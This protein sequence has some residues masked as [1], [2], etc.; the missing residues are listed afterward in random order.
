MYA[1]AMIY[2]VE[3]GRNGDPWEQMCEKVPFCMGTDCKSLYDLCAK[4]GSMPKERRVALDIMD[5]REGLE[6][7]GDN[8]RWV[9]TDHMLVDCMTKNMPPY[10]MLKYLQTGEYSFKYDEDIKNT[11]REESKRRQAAKKAKAEGIQM[12]EKPTIREVNLVLRNGKTWES[13]YLEKVEL[14]PLLPNEV[15]LANFLAF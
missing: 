15:Y 13:E 9:P 10:A 2:E 14:L 8:M 11:K 1:Q 3:H 12:S 6:E 7:F 4:E 5:V